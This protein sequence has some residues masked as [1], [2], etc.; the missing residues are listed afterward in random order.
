M[1]ALAAYQPDMAPNLGAL[2]RICACFDVP[3]DI[4]EPCGFPLSA[5]AL[6]RVA[7]DYTARAR[8]TRHDSW[9][10]FLQARAPRRLVLLTTGARQAH[11]DFRFA[12]GDIVM[13]GRESAGVPRAVAA[14]ADARV[15]IPMPGGGRSLNV[16]VA[17]G[18]VLAEALRQGA[19]RDRG[20]RAQ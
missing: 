5:K 20:A 3:L 15:R 8:I 13:T 1:I 17:A 12:P 2:I 4:I 9:E 16:A 7:M 14:R 10:C 6:R 11:W 19:A 18:I